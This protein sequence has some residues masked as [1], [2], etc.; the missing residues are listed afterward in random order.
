MRTTNRRHAVFNKDW[1]KYLQTEDLTPPIRK[2]GSGLYS[3]DAAIVYDYEASSFLK[4]DIYR[5]VKGFEYITSTGLIVV[6]PTGYL[7]DGASIPRIFRGYINPWGRHA[8]AAIIHDV[9]CDFATI[10]DRNDK[11]VIVSDNDINRIFL[12][13]MS[14]DSVKSSKRV[15][16]ITGVKLYFKYIRPKA[17]DKEP[18]EIDQLKELYA[19]RINTAS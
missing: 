17:P 12:E 7:T 8:R 14:T 3:R 6:V 19:K 15:I 18:L 2:E 11:G 5:V 9:L 13:A 10:Y 1:V 16:I 4:K